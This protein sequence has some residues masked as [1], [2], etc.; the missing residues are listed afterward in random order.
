MHGQ[1]EKEHL[2]LLLA[3][4]HD[5][6]DEHR[7]RLALIQCEEALNLAEGAQVEAKAVCLLADGG[8][9]VA[10]DRGDQRGRDLALLGVEEDDALELVAVRNGE[11]GGNPNIAHVAFCPT[12]WILAVDE[13]FH[14][15]RQTP[16]WHEPPLPQGVPSRTWSPGAHIPLIGSHTLAMWHASTG[17]Q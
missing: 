6:A 14:L 8:H 11:D 15:D 17:G 3:H 7:R 9:A 13:S 16:P 12:A 4:E 5:R 2:V 1:M 10:A